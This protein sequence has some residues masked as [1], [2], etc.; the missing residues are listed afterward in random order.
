MK[1][2]F[3]RKPLAILLALMMTLSMGVTPVF[4]DIDGETN[5][6]DPIPYGGGE[7][8]IAI[9]V[10][11]TASGGNATYF[12]KAVP[13]PAT[14]GVEGFEDEE[15]EVEEGQ[16]TGEYKFDFPANP[17]DEQIKW[18]FFV[19]ASAGDYGNDADFTIMQDYDDSS[20]PPATPAATPTILSAV[21]SPIA[22]DATQIEIDISLEQ[23]PDTDVPV[24]ARASSDG[25]NNWINETGTITGP[26]TGDST[27]VTISIDAN[28][29]G[30]NRTW[31]VQVSLNADYSDATVSGGIIQPPLDTPDPATPA[32]LVS[33]QATPA[34]I[35]HDVTTVS[36]TVKLDKVA[37][38]GVTVD[39]KGVPDGDDINAKTGSVTVPDGADS[40]TGTLTIAPNIST[41]ADVPWAITAS[42]NGTDVSAGTVTQ[43]RAPTAALTGTATI[44]DTSPRV[45][46]TLTASLDGGNSSD[47]SY[48]WKVGGTNA[49]T[50]SNT[51]TVVAGDL[52]KPITVVITAGD[53]SGQVV[54]DPTDAVAAAPPPASPAVIDEVTASSATIEYNEDIIVTVKLDKAP[55]T[56]A[57]VYVKAKASGQMDVVASA[58]IAYPAEVSGS[59]TLD[60]PDNGPAADVEWTVTASLDGVGYADGEDITVTQLKQPTPP[61]APTGLVA[62]AGDQQIEISWTPPSVIGS[63]PI[64]GYEYSLNESGTWQTAGTGTSFTITGLINNTEYKIIVHAVNAF[65]AGA[66]SNVAT[67]T[68]FAV[69]P[70]VKTVT[71]AKAEIAFDEDITVTVSL[72]KAPATSAVVYVKAKA[73]NQTDVVASAAITSSGTD[74]A[75]ITLNIPDNDTG[76]DIEWTVAASFDNVGYENAKNTTV[77]QLKAPLPATLAILT[78]EAPDTKVAAEGTPL[79]I[80]V[81]LNRAVYTET[82]VY[83]QFT[84]TGKPDVFYTDSISAGT[85]AVI[86]VTDLPSNEDSKSE[87]QWTV[88]ASLEDGVFPG[89]AAHQDVFTQLGMTY[90]TG[91]TADFSEI[92][93]DVTTITG[94]VTRNHAIAA[95]TLFLIRAQR[96]DGPPAGAIGRTIASNNTSA[97][98]SITIPANTGTE[99]IEWTVMAVSDNVFDGSDGDVTTTVRQLAPAPA[100]LDAVR[101]LNTANVDADGEVRI[102]EVELDEAMAGETEVFVK[103]GAADGADAL[104]VTPMP[105]IVP[106]GEL[107]ATAAVTIPANQS[108][109]NTVTWYVT[110]SL[111]DDYSDPEKTTVTQ[112]AAVPELESIQV[113]ANIPAAATEIPVTVTLDKAAPTGGTTVYL[114]ATDGTTSHTGI[115]TVP[116]GS[117]T[118]TGT[119]AIA[120]NT[121]PAEVVWTVTGTLN[122]D[123]NTGAINAG[124]AVKQLGYVP[125]ATSGN[126]IDTVTASP[127]TMPAEGTV[128]EVTVA[129]K[130]GFATPAQPI[131]VEAQSGTQK[132]SAMAV[133]Q[134]DADKITITITIPAN[135]SPTAK[136]WNIRA[137]FDEEFIDNLEYALDTVTQDG[138]VAPL[139]LIEVSPGASNIDYDGEITVNVEL[140]ELV[141]SDTTVYVKAIPNG[142]S[143]DAETVEVTVPQGS[144]TGTGTIT[145][146]PNL[147]DTAIVWALTGSLNADYETDAVDGTM[148]VTQAAAPQPELVSVA[149][150]NASNVPAAG[151]ARAVTMTVESVPVPTTVYL[152]VVDDDSNT[153]TVAPASVTIPAG[154]TATSA[155]V[156][157]P[158]NLGETQLSWAVEAHKYFRFCN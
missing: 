4:A 30:L 150:D 17:F 113:P 97:T 125:K 127:A 64:T 38:G 152:R 66:S 61:G 79:N 68:P 26:G 101:F 103:V 92:A 89:T 5:D 16:D 149:F 98:Y 102:I 55:A 23:D 87:L 36:V 25:G 76:A 158:E 133:M 78:V 137:A 145:I 63:S 106:A 95:D 122:G 140:S 83:L 151:G 96:A 14:S 65:G 6:G 24:Y 112:D 156:T 20:P 58:A 52:G 94:T 134:T 44:S 126:V 56:S 10:D 93:A 9:T 155:T 32:K 147:T 132:A 157:I 18:D 67:A 91:V 37:S 41:T 135:T 109:D 11:E 120:A 107:T 48:Q 129:L 51:Y 99:Y 8:N 57:V 123:Y 21:V 85:S 80:T 142:V 141:A 110:A 121:D 7:Y 54:S 124:N 12:L 136:V 71:P 115:V 118:G 90:L 153:A 131:W 130:N 46:D 148:N 116:A 59:I 69:P 50:N 60:I 15:F 35:A 111:E 27:T 128:I 144:K 139:T 73:D 104:E 49:G 75:P 143:G 100:V 13:D 84:A 62:T 3:L 45:G 40:A 81:T 86:S 138:Y 53:K 74:S 108:S 117:T 77:T 42:L 1:T 72:D 19:A 39:I 82:P 34:T 43:L 33:A 28:N 22:A 47:L 70:V 114:T 146:D 2:N 88:E 31:V 154:Q 105:V 119:I 29:T